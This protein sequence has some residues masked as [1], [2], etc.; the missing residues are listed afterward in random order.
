M[1]Y[2]APWRAAL[3]P[4]S[5]RG[6]PF[7]VQAS[8]QSG[9]G[10]NVPHEYPKSDLGWAEPMG[11]KLRR[12]RV[13]AF[14][15]GPTYTAGRDALVAA[16]EVDG[17]GTLVHP[18]LGTM[19]ASCDVY[20]THESAERGGLCILEL[21][22]VEAGSPASDAVTADSQSRVGSAATQS[23]STASGSLDAGLKTGSNGLVAGPV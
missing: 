18:T 20:D 3:R 11:R 7:E 21:A 1:P 17:P 6:V 19:Q 10:R 16:T 5:F 12:W 8:G 4:A 13:T 22:F 15:I 14:V 23:D 9:G 2:V